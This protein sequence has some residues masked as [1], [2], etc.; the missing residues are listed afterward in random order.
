MRALIL[1]TAAASAFGAGVSETPRWEWNGSIQQGKAVE[2]R[3]VT[4]DI[5]ALPSDTG[6][7]EV[8]AWIERD[9]TT[10]RVDIRALQ[11]TSGMTFCAVRQG[12][13]ECATDIPSSPGVRVD[14]E[15]RVP[16]GVRLNAQTVNGEI[17]ARSLA[18]DISAATV[19]GAVTV[20][21]SGTVQAR[22]VN[23]SIDASLLGPL[24]SKAPKFSAVNGRISVELPTDVTS[25]VHA[26]THN[27]RVV[28]HLPA[29]RGT[30]TEQKLEGQ[31]GPGG[32]GNSLV[33]RTLNGSIELRQR[34]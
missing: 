6:K 12:S 7:V 13:T 30:A 17:E 26:E 22:T 19:N 29:F 5:H 8:A 25:V 2:I 27:G 10:E 1:L 34:F 33:I 14:F 9:G 4:G 18:S 16:P 11:S 21:T 24:R 20:S 28:A 3:G 31:I 32:C 15:V 23:G